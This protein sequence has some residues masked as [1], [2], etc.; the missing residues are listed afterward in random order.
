[1]S[2]QSSPEDSFEE[3]NTDDVVETDPSEQATSDASDDD[4]E[5]AGV[6]LDDINRDD[7]TPDMQSVYD[8]FTEQRDNMNAGFT[9]A[10]QTASQNLADAENWQMIENDPVLAKAIN[11]AIYRRD[12]GLPMDGGVEPKE[13]EP[14]ALPSQEDDPEGY[15]EALMLRTVNK[16]LDTRLPSLQEEIGTVSRHVRGQQTNLEFVN[17]VA[18]Y[19]AAESLGLGKLNAIRNRYPQMP[20][21]EAFHLAAMKNPALLS[22]G[23]QTASGKTVVK[24]PTGIEKPSGGKTGRNVLDLPDNIAELRKAAKASRDDGKSVKQRLLESMNKLRSQGEAV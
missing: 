4:K 24:K 21:E 10:R 7:L 6:T 23:E 5:I 3:Q 19:P 9:Q 14:E 18:K 17:L 8:S 13:K 20:L 2:I 16:A 11:D 12:N 1:M 15:L 22:K